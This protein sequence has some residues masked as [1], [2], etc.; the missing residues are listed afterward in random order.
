MSARIDLDAYFRRIGYTGSR[1]ATL[2]TLRAI[3]LLH[4]QAIVF[5]NLDPLM[6]RTP[7]LA[8][9]ALE[10]KLVHGDRGGYCF[11]Q[12]LLLI[13]VLN[14]LGVPVRGLAARVL[15]NVSP[16][17][18]PTRS[19][20]ALLV[21][22]EGGTFLMDVGF[23]GLTLTMPLRFEPGLEQKTPHEPFRLV[24]SDSEY[25]MQA[26]VAGEWRPLYRFDLQPQLQRDYE[27]INWYL[28]NHPESRFVNN[29]VVARAAP[30]RRYALFNDA[31]A[32]HSLQ[33]TTER[34]VLAD[35]GEIRRTLAATFGLTLADSGALDAALARAK[36]AGAKLAAA[37]P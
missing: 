7:E 32:I 28:A 19:H 22:V 21:E 9:A 11:E 13:H 6:G 27:V 26:F 36:A 17:V 37:K 25:I 10:R 8:A 4:P 2:A 1:T 24:A 12:N 30:D 3:H 31:F 15:H 35:A 18:V 5:E 20:M 23:G 16:G 34:T 33:G 29:L 14:A